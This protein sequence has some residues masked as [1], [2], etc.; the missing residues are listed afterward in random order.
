MASADFETLMDNTDLSDLVNKAV[1]GI[2]QNIITESAGNMS[3]NILLKKTL[4]EVMT[5][6]DSFDEGLFSQ[7]E[8]F[9]QILELIRPIIKGAKNA[10]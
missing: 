8:A 1:G 2:E 4:G 10:E 3:E 7:Q 5:I 6:V 9:I